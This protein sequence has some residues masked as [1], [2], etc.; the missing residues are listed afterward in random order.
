LTI[1]QVIV[2]VDRGIGALVNKIT[3]GLAGF[4]PMTPCPQASTGNLKIDE[5]GFIRMLMHHSQ[6]LATSEFT[7]ALSWFCGEPLP[8]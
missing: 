8:N 2:N 5:L 4:E 3:V 1:L 6:Y 7:L